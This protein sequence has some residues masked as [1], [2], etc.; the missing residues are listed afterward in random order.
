[1]DF[2]FLTIARIFRCGRS[3]ALVIIDQLQ[4]YGYGYGFSS[5]TVELSVEL[6]LNLQQAINNLD[7]A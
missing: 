5:D 1:L 4:N 6:L 3:I 2:G 7:Q